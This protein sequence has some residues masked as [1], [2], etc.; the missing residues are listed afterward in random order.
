MVY[1]QRW[2]KLLTGGLL[3]SVL[4]LAMALAVP[5]AVV[6]QESD[7]EEVAEGATAENSL[8]KPLAER[9]LLLDGTAVEGLIAA[10]G[11]RGHI[12]LSRDDG[13]TWVQ[14]QVPT[15]TAL[16]GVFF[17]DDQLGWAV[18]HDASI[19]R[20]RD[21][22]DTWELLHYAPEEE[23]PF[24]DVWFS[25]AD[26][27]LV[28]GAYGFFLK[29]RDGGDTWTDFAI[30]TADD[31]VDEE[32]DEY[33]Y[34]DY[35]ADM[36]L[37]DISRSANGTLYIAAEAGA[38]YR[39]V[40]DGETWL[41]LPSPYDGSFFGTLPL[42]GDSLLLFGLR[43]HLF[44]SDDAGDSWQEVETG[45]EALL[46]SGVKLDD[47]TIV[48]VGLAGTVLVSSD[49]GQT[50]ELRQQADRQGLTTALPGADGGLIALGEAGAKRLTAAM[51]SG[52]AAQ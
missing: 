26:T 49:G 51:I 48:I 35:G 10:V 38:S 32:S 6:A 44:R 23:R 14:A 33:D 27:G 9:S 1:L 2:S 12:L 22:G 45:S 25:D 16:T 7:G 19:V 11:E 42:E 4:A 28:I 52:E 21:G 5:F 29:T 8:L 15:R 31:A 37:N 50:F 36:H 43:G 34:Y 40:D 20:T 39:S 46:T 17:L 41:E 3:C 47:G 30:L 24:L 18:G 13:A